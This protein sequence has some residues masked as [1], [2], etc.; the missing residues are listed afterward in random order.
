MR[1]IGRIAEASRNGR[2]RREE[3]GGSVKGI[4]AESI[5]KD[6][7]LVPICLGGG[8]LNREQAGFLLKNPWSQK[9]S[10]KVR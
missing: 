6:R 2:L 5:R 8:P 7:K 4:S 1:K 10:L 9:M 3:S